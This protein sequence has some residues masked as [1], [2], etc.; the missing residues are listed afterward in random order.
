M[1]EIGVPPRQNGA[2]F[3]E[4]IGD[5]AADALRSISRIVASEATGLSSACPKRNPCAGL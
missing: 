1:V 4:G 2:R 3:I 5:D